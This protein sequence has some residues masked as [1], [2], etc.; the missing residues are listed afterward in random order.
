MSIARLRQGLTYHLHGAHRQQCL[1]GLYGLSVLGEDSDNGPGHGSRHLA[2]DLGVGL[3][4]SPL[5]R[6][7]PVASAHSIS[8]R[9]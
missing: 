4:Q 8:S 1:P 3:W 6:G 7:W 9:T 5:G 2:L